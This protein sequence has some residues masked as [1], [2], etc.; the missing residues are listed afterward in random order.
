MSNF[1]SPRATFVCRI[2]C[3]SKADSIVWMGEGE[4][5]VVIFLKMP[6]FAV[7]IFKFLI[8]CGIF[9]RIQKSG[10]AANALIDPLFKCA[11]FSLML[12]LSIRVF[13]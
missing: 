13:S 1:S 2:W 6:C 9:F 7:L 4:G 8:C 3:D 10:I 5:T 11:Y 12:Y